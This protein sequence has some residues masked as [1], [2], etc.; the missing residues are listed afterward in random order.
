MVSV[1]PLG[2]CLT[3][4][5]IHCA[6]KTHVASE[7]VIQTSLSRLAVFVKLHLPYS[8]SAN[9]TQGWKTPW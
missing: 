7:L 8:I 1:F 3:K 4:R 9:R 2:V 5:N 6:R